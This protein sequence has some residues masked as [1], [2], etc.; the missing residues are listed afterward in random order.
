MQEISNTLTRK[1]SIIG[2]GQGALGATTVNSGGMSGGDSYIQFTGESIV[3]NGGGGGGPSSGGWGG[4][5]GT[6]AGGTG[7]IPNFPNQFDGGFGGPGLESNFTGTP[8]YYA[9]GGAGGS[10]SS[11]QAALGGVGGG[12]NGAYYPQAPATNGT[13]GLGSGGG[14]GS[15]QSPI[16]PAGRGGS[17]LV[18]IKY[19]TADMAGYT[20]TGGV[21][22][23]NGAYTLHTFT[24]GGTLTIS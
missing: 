12:G 3:A 6:G 17:G 13:N 7:G 15:A 14:G 11:N 21:K 10:V 19:L 23:T 1:T 22:T 18:I 5:G 2:I 24:S 4:S 20:A 8:T 16:A 9:G